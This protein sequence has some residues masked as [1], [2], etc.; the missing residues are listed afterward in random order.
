MKPEYVL[1][2]ENLTKRYGDVTAV[3]D[4]SFRVKAGSFVTLLGPSGCGKTTTL[5]LIAGFEQPDAGRI[6]LNGEDIQGKAPFERQVNTVFQSYALFPHMTVAENIAYGLESRKLPKAEIKQEVQDALDLVDLSSFG[7]RYPDQLSGGQRQRVAVARAFVN[8]PD[9][10]LLD[11]P[12]GALDLKLRHHLQIE[13]KRLQQE[14]GIAF[15]YVTHDQEEALTMSDEIIVMNHAVI[16]QIA[17]P[18][19]MYNQPS[20]HFVADFLGGSNI[21]PVDAIDASGDHLNIRILGLDVTL[22]NPS[23]QSGEA[24]SLRP[25]KIAIGTHAQTTEHQV[26]ATVTARVFKG[27]VFEFLAQVDDGPELTVHSIEGASALAVGKP[28]TLGFNSADLVLVEH[29]EGGV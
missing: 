16:E 3:D 22:K 24:I 15:V 6:I 10:L 8:K 11:E 12:L 5:R 19:T 28:V 9:I 1:E 21:V 27:T 20:T 17:D 2:L 4:I 18:I 14:L 23:G 29:S 25:E 26:S 13:L 7:D